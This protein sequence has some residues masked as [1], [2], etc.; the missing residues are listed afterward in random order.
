MG[1]GRFKEM[2]LETNKGNHFRIYNNKEEAEKWL[3]NN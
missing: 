2:A 3:L 1:K